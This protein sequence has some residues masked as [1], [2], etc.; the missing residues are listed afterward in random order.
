MSKIFLEILDPERQKVFKQLAAFADHGYLAGD[1]ALAMQLAHRVSVDFDVFVYKPIS[2]QLRS[3]I[4]K[5]VSIQQVHLNTTD[6]YTFTTR[7]NIE[8]TF[9]WFDYQLIRPLIPTSSLSLSSIADIA[10][11]KAN[12]LGYRAVW[13]DYVDL[14][15]LMKEERVAIDDIVTWAKQKHPTEFVE[16]QFLEQLVYFNDLTIAPIQ[17][18][19]KSYITEEIQSFLGTTVDEYLLTRKKQQKS[20]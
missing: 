11:N 9:L 5:H 20:Q 2:T 12:T 10:A 15:W 8:I 19:K 13:R 1:T 16:A 7:E 4:A 3:A 6:Q 17:F 18:L 14:F